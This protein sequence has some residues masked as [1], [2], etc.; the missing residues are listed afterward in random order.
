MVDLASFDD[1]ADR[2]MT[3]AL[4]GEVI[5]A[6]DGNP[7]T[8]TFFGPDSHQYA[9]AR[10]KMLNELRKLQARAI[11]TAPVTVQSEKAVYVQFYAEITRA[12]SAPLPVRGKAV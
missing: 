9:V 1:T 5:K 11:P 6:D 2:L 12:W 3:V 7:I 4:G 8:I 10:N